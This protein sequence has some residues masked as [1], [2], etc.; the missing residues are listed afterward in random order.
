MSKNL[1][2]VLGNQLFDPNFL[3]NKQ[4]DLVFMAE[5]FE[6]CTF[7]KHHKLKILMF[8]TAMREYREELKRNNFEVVYK[9]INLPS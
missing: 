2:V 5:D 4:I 8:L 3:K 1:L 7:Q 9:G 6:L